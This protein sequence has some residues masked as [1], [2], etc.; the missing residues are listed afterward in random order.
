MTDSRPIWWVAA[1]GDP[2]H[3]WV[4]AFE[5]LT[6]ES[7]ADHYGLAAGIFVA[8]VRR[9]SG[10]GPTFTELFRELFEESQLHPEWPE[11][12]NNVMRAAILHSYRLHVAI[13]WKRRG[14]IN[15]DPGVARSLRVGRVFREHSRARQAAR[16]Q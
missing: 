16:A 5:A 11:G 3:E 6:D 12:L 7:L 9:R 14:W 15:W 2:P 13:Q 4:V 1:A 8:R 10:H